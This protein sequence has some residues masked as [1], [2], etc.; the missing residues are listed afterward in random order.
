MVMNTDKFFHNE[1][2][3]LTVMFGVC[4]KP[5]ASGVVFA[6]VRTVRKLLHRIFLLDKSLVFRYDMQ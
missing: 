5:H 2:G 6:L 3:S 1:D 4:G